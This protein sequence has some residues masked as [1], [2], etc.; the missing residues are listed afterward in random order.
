MTAAAGCA[1]TRTG[2]S[3]RS[4]RTRPGTSAPASPT[5]C[6]SNFSIWSAVISI[7]A[8]S[9]STTR[10]I[11]IACS[12]PAAWPLRMARAS[13]ITWWCRRRRSPGI[14]SAGGAHWQSYRIDGR[15]VFDPA[16]DQDR[17]ELDRLA[18]W[19]S[20]PRARRSA[21]R[22]TGRSSPVPTSS[23]ARPASGRHRRQ[24]GQR[25]AAFP[26]PGVAGRTTQIRFAAS[27]PS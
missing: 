1:R 18:S 4:S 23:R 8:A 21:Q 12:A 7:P 25:V 16:R 20:K 2:I 26:R 13:P 3:T 15:P 19:Q 6:R 24:H 10:P 11:P 9:S 5:C 22:W 14:S 27:A 17:A